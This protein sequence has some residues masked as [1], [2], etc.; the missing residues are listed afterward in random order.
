MVMVVLKTERGHRVRRM[1]L[2]VSIRAGGEAAGGGRS[3][4][5]VWDASRPGA[6]AWALL[7]AT[8]TSQ[9]G[10]E[11]TVLAAQS[12]RRGGGRGEGRRD[13][14]FGQPLGVCDGCWGGNGSGG[15]GEIPQRA[16]LLDHAA[17]Q[18]LVGPVCLLD[19]VQP[20]RLLLNCTDGE[21]VVGVWSRH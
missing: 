9:G 10:A 11:V 6:S 14:A 1:A 17:I 21:V 5:V 4:T 18:A 2:V 16:V 3:A 15:R 13:V 12:W 7:L 19:A 8:R 20:L